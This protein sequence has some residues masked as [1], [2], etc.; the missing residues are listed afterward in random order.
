MRERTM[1]KKNRIAWLI[2]FPII[3]CFVMTG[4][5]FVYLYC[6]ETA[7]AKSIENA[8]ALTLVGIAVSFFIGVQ[9]VNA[10][11]RNDVAELDGKIAKFTEMEQLI[12]NYA[13]RN[14]FS[15]L[16]FFRTSLK[17]AMEKAIYADFIIEKSVVLEESI[18]DNPNEI[19]SLVQNMAK[20]E[21]NFKLAVD[22][23]YSNQRKESRY[24]ADECFKLCNE[25]MASHTKYDVPYM[26][27]VLGYLYFK[28]C[29]LYFYKNYLYLPKDDDYT[30]FLQSGLKSIDCFFNTSWSH[31]NMKTEFNE[32]Q[33]SALVVLTKKETGFI[34]YLLHLISEYSRKGEQKYINLQYLNNLIFKL[35]KDAD[36]DLFNNEAVSQMVKDYAI[37]QEN[38]EKNYKEAKK[39][40]LRALHIDNTVPKNYQVYLSL[41]LKEIENNNEHIFTIEFDE[42]EPYRY[43]FHVNKNELNQNFDY[44]EFN[45]SKQIM[46]TAISLFPNEENIS[47]LYSRYL[48]MLSFLTGISES[49][50][51]IEQ[52]ISYI[53]NAEKLK[54]ENYVFDSGYYFAKIRILERAER[55]EDARKAAIE[56][57]KIYPER[58]DFCNKKI[59]KYN[60]YLNI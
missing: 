41:L 56:F 15:N 2:V 49:E 26:K 28:Q 58:H 39:N 6:Y 16:A 43:Y 51:A 25:L 42:Q 12:T 10:I 27:F 52:S 14:A 37:N 29:D 23:F 1:G 34:T 55:I 47:I 45:N 20:L 19:N 30:D 35:L 38:K 48:T 17:Y 3:I 31:T 22:A 54:P 11:S 59:K 8:L 57:L 53:E 44:S 24:H 7:E 21:L 18:Q 40:Y 9:I 5:V 46:E 60:A 50:T 13:N 4:A 36:F 33:K 32:Q